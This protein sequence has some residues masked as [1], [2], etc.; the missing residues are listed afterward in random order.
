MLPTERRAYA[1]RMRT[2]G[3]GLGVAVMGGGLVSVQNMTHADDLYTTYRIVRADRDG[4]GVPGNAPEAC[5]DGNTKAEGSH[6]F[7]H[8][9]K[10]DSKFQL[11]H[12]SDVRTLHG[13]VVE[14]VVDGNKGGIK[15]L[16]GDA[17]GNVYVL[18][19]NDGDYQKWRYLY[20]YTEPDGTKQR[21]NKTYTLL[22]NVA[23]GRCLAHGEEAIVEA[24]PEI[25][26]VPPWEWRHYLAGDTRN[27][28][29]LA[30]VWRLQPA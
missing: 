20:T 28:W 30:M 13:V 22:Q 2:A 6:A 3:F 9:C 4:D 16:H 25:S 17:L 14:L 29:L 8:T 12:P 5:L 10:K 19:C 24:V 23:T 7:L 15:C 21:S 27:N 11:W 1:M 18:A 26:C